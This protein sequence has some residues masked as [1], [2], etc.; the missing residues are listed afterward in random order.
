VSK[1]W[2]ERET[3]RIVAVEPATWS[4]DLPNDGDN[5]QIDANQRKIVADIRCDESGARSPVDRRHRAYRNQRTNDAKNDDHV[6]LTRRSSVAASGARAWLWVG[7]FSHVKTR[8]HAGSPS[9]A[10]I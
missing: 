10:V 5:N 6:N 8:H 7:G 1:R 3:D 2:N 4:N 9:T